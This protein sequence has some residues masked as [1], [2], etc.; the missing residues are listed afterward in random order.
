M[1]S[2]T[3]TTQETNTHTQVS[4]LLSARAVRDRKLQAGVTQ[5]CLREGINRDPEP[6]QLSARLGGARQ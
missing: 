4:G 5:P 1:T 6:T 2:A 3:F